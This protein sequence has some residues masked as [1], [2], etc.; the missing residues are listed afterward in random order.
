[1][2]NLKSPMGKPIFLLMLIAIALVQTSCINS[3]S[4]MYF[5][6]LPDTTRLQLEKLIPPVPTIQVN[7][8]VEIR[9]GGDN[10][11][12]VA[13]ISQ[14]FAGGNETGSLLT[15]VDVNGA[16]ELPQIGKLI[17]A[18]LTREEAKDLIT[19]AYKEY[20]VNPVI[21]VKFGE[22]HF[23]VLGEVKM[24]GMKA[25]KTEKVNILEALAQAGD[26]TQYAQ[27]DKVKIIREVNGNRELITINLNDKA[28]LNSPDYYIHTNDVIYVEPKSVKQVTDNFQR[29]LLY[30]TGITS[31]LT[32]FLVAIKR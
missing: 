10:E 13:Y 7:D 26:L 21:M 18:G 32:V 31:F 30:I 20:L 3:K 5:N 1:M 8:E 29:T 19:K 22:F 6:N 15:V 16:I 23:S 4:I 11:K 27:R 17:I 28:I 24:P 14:H 25:S 12:T 9:I 2:N